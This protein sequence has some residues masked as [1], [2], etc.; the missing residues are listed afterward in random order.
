VT[1]GVEQPELLSLAHSRDGNTD[2]PDRTGATSFAIFRQRIAKKLSRDAE[3]GHVVVR[4]LAKRPL[5]GASLERRDA[6]GHRDRPAAKRV[7]T[8][9]PPDAFRQTEER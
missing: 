1:G 6:Q 5:P 3:D 7:T 4:R 2:E 8:K 9:A